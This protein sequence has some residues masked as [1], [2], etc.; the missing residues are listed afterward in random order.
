[1]NRKENEPEWGD[2][3]R[4][5]RTI[6]LWK[7]YRQLCGRCAVWEKTAPC[8]VE[9]C[10]ETMYLHGKCKKHWMRE[11]GQL[12]NSPRC[13]EPRLHIHPDGHDKEAY[14]CRKH[15]INYRRQNNK[16]VQVRRLILLDI[17][18]VLNNHRHNNRFPNT[19]LDYKDE[20]KPL[21]KRR[22]SWDKWN[23][24]H[25]KRILEMTGAKVYIHSSWSMHF[26][27]DVFRDIFKLYRLPKDTIVGSGMKKIG[28]HSS[29]KEDL[30]YLM[31]RLPLSFDIERCVIVDDDVWPSVGDRFDLEG[32]KVEAVRPDSEV[33]LVGDDVY[34]VA[35]AISTHEERI[36]E[37]LVK[38][39]PWARCII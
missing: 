39:D 8:E 34:R 17:D 11:T 26:D 35:N 25:L 24:A 36:E 29:R 30:W 31:E 9:R 16:L 23:V 15:F 2:C 32:E 37:G 6:D 19:M 38:V 10:E 18:G 1:M 3:K 21:T 4:C 28:M 7:T 13:D 27:T 20:G 5:G 22:V 33:G 12:C 14:Q